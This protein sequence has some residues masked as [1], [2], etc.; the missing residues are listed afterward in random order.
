MPL[1]KGKVKVYQEEG[2]DRSL[3]FIGEDRIDHTPK[4]ET[5]E[6]YLGDAFDLVCEGNNIDSYKDEKGIRT[7][8]WKYTIKN[9]KEEPALM[10][11]THNIYDRNWKMKDKSHD[12]Q[13]ETSNKIVFWVEVPANTE[14]SVTFEYKVDERIFI[15]KN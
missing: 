8:K 11:I 4:N 2:N 10:K 13:K 5:V 7:E 9:R 1:P 3:E 14:E 15:T 6:L 12:Y